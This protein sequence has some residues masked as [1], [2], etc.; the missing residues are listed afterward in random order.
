MANKT[1]DDAI[2]DF[3]FTFVDENEVAKTIRKENETDVKMVNDRLENVMAAIRPFLKNLQ[4]N[5]EQ[6]YLK[7]PDRAKKVAEFER[8]LNAIADGAKP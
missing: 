6:E 3:G 4:K 7:W 2:N 8:K 5:P 1:V